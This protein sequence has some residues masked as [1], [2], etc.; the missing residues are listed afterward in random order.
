MRDGHGVSP[1]QC[2]CAIF[3]SRKLKS[4]YEKT[5]DEHGDF[6]KTTRRRL[7]VVTFDAFNHRR[8]S[9]GGKAA[10]EIHCGI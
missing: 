1:V 10:L 8:M 5:F 4:D 2:D 7:I 9:S 3:L 6:E